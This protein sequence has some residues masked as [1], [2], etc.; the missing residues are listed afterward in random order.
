M[1]TKTAAAKRLVEAME[2]LFPLQRDTPFLLAA[3][4]GVAVATAVCL[5]L[6]IVLMNRGGRKTGTAT[7]TKATKPTPMLPG[8]PIIGST[9]EV[10]ANMPRFLDWMLERTRAPELGGADGLGGWVGGHTAAVWLWSW[11]GVVCALYLSLA[12]CC[13]GLDRFF[14]VAAEEGGTARHDCQGPLMGGLRAAA[15]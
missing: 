10:L 4:A 11:S 13:V 8:Y 5:L 15:A 9:V 14:F 12:V 6:H 2:G 1:A 7:T 3:A